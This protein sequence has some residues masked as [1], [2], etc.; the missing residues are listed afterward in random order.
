MNRIRQS[1]RS[2]HGTVQSSG[3]I[4]REAPKKPLAPSG[5]GSDAFHGAPLREL[6]IGE[7]IHI[8]LS[9]VSG[10]PQNNV[11]RAPLP[12]QSA[13]NNHNM[14]PTSLVS[15]LQP[16]GPRLRIPSEAKS[17]PSKDLRLPCNPSSGVPFQWHGPRHF[18]SRKVLQ[19][20]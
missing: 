13:Y 20:A 2:H 14:A 18:R 6:R 11:H 19:S 16:A 15:H 8:I 3:E 1:V 10:R 12:G 9:K 4:P 5:H 7:D 17:K